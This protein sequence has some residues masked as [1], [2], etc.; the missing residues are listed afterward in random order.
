MTVAIAHG[1]AITILRDI[2]PDTAG[3]ILADPPYSSGGI[4]SAARTNQTTTSKYLRT[5]SSRESLPP[6]EGDNRDQRSYLA[7]SV[8]WMTEARRI[9][10][11]GCA[12]CVFTDW[13]QLP[14][15]TDAIQAAGFIWRGI[16]TWDKGQGGRPYRGF[17]T[18]HSEFIVWGTKGPNG[19]TT[20][21]PGVISRAN[22]HN[23]RDHHQTT[24][25]VSL[26]A[27]LIKLAPPRST[28]IDPF[29]GSGS[30]LI[31]AD[32]AGADALGIEITSAYA[33]RATKRLENDR[34][35]ISIFDTR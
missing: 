32:R 9:L 5:G 8:L 24:K 7:W 4:T 14:T 22:T 19:L 2:P 27:E 10:M 20:Y 1:D 12:I 18:G 34:A 17:A 30:A 25:P 35:Q 29:T 33:A 6:F 13:R 11:P 28:I 3:L 26:L 15:T 16:A 21:L 31:A 23:E